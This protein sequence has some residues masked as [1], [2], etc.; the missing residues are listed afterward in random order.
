MHDEALQTNDVMM[1]A[2]NLSWQPTKRLAHEETFTWSSTSWAD[3]D[4]HDSRTVQAAGFVL[5]LSALMQQ[6]RGLDYD[7]REGKK[8]IWGNDIAKML[9][10]DQTKGTK[11]LARDPD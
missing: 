8:H 11:P 4:T 1:S 7:D 5:P 10:H 2:V 9:H 6:D 3:D